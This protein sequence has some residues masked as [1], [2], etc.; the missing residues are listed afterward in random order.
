[1]LPD[2]FENYGG[3]AELD[4]MQDVC[5]YLRRTEDNHKLGFITCSVASVMSNSVWPYGLQPAMLL[6][7]WD[8]PG[9][10]TGV[11]CHALLQGIF[12]TQRLNL[13]LLCLLHWQVGSLPLAS[14]G[15]LLSAFLLFSW[16]VVLTLYNPRDWSTPGPP[17]SHHLL[18]FSQIHVPLHQWCHPAIS[19]T[20][21]LFSFCPQSFP[22]SGTFPISWLLASGDQNT[23]ASAS[24]SASA[25]FRSSS[26]SFSC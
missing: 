12:P 26:L 22:A 16:P 19:S 2:G 7:P 20:V 25:L 9:K 24:A 4:K 5:R 13:C 10:N 1:M 14:P 11:G 6:R 23:G 3:K 8:S 17:V 21:F 18:K 15:K